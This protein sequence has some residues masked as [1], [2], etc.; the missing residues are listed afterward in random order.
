MQYKNGRMKHAT[1]CNS[2]VNLLDEHTLIEDV[3][4]LIEDVH[5]LIEDE[6]TLIE[7]VDTLEKVTHHRLKSHVTQFVYRTIIAISK[8]WVEIMQYVTY[9]S[10]F[11]DEN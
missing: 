3:H 2:I 9:S 7:D 8:W 4:T 1:Y 11:V 5:T 6:H 10:I